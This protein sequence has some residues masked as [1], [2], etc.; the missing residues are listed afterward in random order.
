MFITRK[1]LSRRT[2]LRSTMGTFMALPMLDA[3]VPALAAQTRGRTATPFRFGAIYMPNGVY[4]PMWHPEESGPNFGFKRIMQPLEPFRDQLVTI[5]KLRAPE[6]SLHLGASAAW[7]NGVGPVQDARDLGAIE[8]R[9]TLDQYIADRTAGDTP[10]RSL[11]VGTEDMGTSAGACDGF[12]CVFFNTLS[13][14]DDTSPLPVEITPRLTFERMFG[15][16]GTPAQR[17]ARLKQK[18]S[19]LDLFAGEVAKI[20]RTLGPADKAVLDDYVTNVREVEQQIDRMDARANRLVDAPEVPLGIPDSFDD[21]MTVTYNLMHLAFRADISRVFTFLVG[22]EGTGRGYAHIGVPDRHHSISHHRKMPDKLEAY[23]K[24]CTYQVTKFG[25]FV[26]KLRSTPDG[27]GSLLDHSLLY[28]GSG[29]SDGNP[30]D[31]FNPPAVLVGSANGRLKGNRHVV[32]KGEPTAT[33]LL[34]L[35]DM[36]GAEVPKMGASTSRLAL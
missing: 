34:A 23:A 5:S 4:P 35:A 11:Q 18:R 27:D 31:R 25:E 33:L 36:A 6:G 30:H 32:A 28:W 26:Q 16:T 20:Q 21:H 9:K 12:P 17:L 22:H 14:R 7:L 15:E 10:L 29:M 3:M 2:F 1:H 13:W 24:I 19:M 8:S